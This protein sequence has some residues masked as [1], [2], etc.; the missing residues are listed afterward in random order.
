[1][2]FRIAAARIVA[3]L[4]LLAFVSAASAQGDDRY[5]NAPSAGGGAAGMMGPSVDVHVMR[6]VEERRQG[7][8]Y[9][10]AAVAPGAPCANLRIIIA[11]NVEGR[12]HPTVISAANTFLGARTGNGGTATLEP[13][14]YT[15]THVLCINYGSRQILIGPFARFRI[16]G[17]EVVNLGTL[18][19]YLG[20]GSAPGKL[21]I[22][23]K[24][25]AGMRAEARAAF[26]QQNPKTVA[27]MVD[28]YMTPLGGSQAAGVPAAPRVPSSEFLK[29]NSGGQTFGDEAQQ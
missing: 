25:V 20:R 19:L 29:E 18:T 15:V 13:G 10:D 16:S 7:F 27:R 12:W 1:M 26:R 3:S 14:D 9:I 4:L 23:G 24:S 22:T 11:R 6:L 8:I 21:A 5:P 28:R 17:G 2:M